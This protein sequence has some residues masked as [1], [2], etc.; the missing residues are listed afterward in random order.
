MAVILKSTKVRVDGP[1][2]LAKRVAPR[3]CLFEVQVRR[4]GSDE[5][6]EKGGGVGARNAFRELQM[7]GENT[8]G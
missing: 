2:P 5:V 6:K 8:P 1:F 3:M 7:Y 4:D